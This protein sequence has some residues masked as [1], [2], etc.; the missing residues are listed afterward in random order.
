[1]P[2]VATVFRKVEV[3]L[4]RVKTTVVS[5]GVSTFSRKVRSREDWL[6][7][8]VRKVKA[9]SSAVR[10][11]PSVKN[12]SSRIAKVQVRPSSERL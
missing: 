7:L 4:T 5:S 8:A 9:T 3:G 10:G 2:T 1:M 11:S 12:T 6:S